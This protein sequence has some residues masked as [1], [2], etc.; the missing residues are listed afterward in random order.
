M[1]SSILEKLSPEFFR[2]SGFFKFPIFFWVEMKKKLTYIGQ[3]R[4]SLTTKEIQTL[5]N[6]SVGILQNAQNFGHHGKQILSFPK[7]PQ[8]LDWFGKPLNVHH[9][10]TQG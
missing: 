9:G 3:H 5:E 4:K 6:I 1:F 10:S 7:M 8:F 2:A